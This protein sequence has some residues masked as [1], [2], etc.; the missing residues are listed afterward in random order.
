[1]LDEGLSDSVSVDM[2][3]WT[4]AAAMAHLKLAKLGGLDR[5]MQAGCKL[6]EARVPPMV[7]QMNEGAI[8]TLAAAHAAVAL[9]AGHRE[10]YSPA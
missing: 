2:L 3:L 1:M 7:G 10:R 4:R 6:R 9:G 5:L 8:S